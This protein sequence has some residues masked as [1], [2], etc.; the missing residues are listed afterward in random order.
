[1]IKR[2]FSGV[3]VLLLAGCQTA[4]PL[5]YWGHY[6]PLTYQSYANPGKA[7][8]EIQIAQLEEDIQKAAAAHL[9]VSPGLHA[10]LGYLYYQL[11]KLDLAQ[12]E[13]ET[14]KTL[15]PESGPFIDRLLKQPQTPPATT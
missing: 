13:F 14:E 11:G 3:F 2:I 12:R 5:Y 15:F 10:H 9:P 8:P 7:T 1:M 4:R 6:E